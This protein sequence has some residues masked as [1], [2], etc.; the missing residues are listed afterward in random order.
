MCS[1]SVNS[2]IGAC[3]LMVVGHTFCNLKLVGAKSSKASVLDPWAR[4][5]VAS[6]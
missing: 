3:G 6:L 5:T 1:L 4:H 2:M